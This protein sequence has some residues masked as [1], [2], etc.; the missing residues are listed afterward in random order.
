M[1]G[2]PGEARPGLR[3]PRLP[4]GRVGDALGDARAAVGRL[5]PGVSRV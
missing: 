1:T 5:L 2:P 3:A 4:T